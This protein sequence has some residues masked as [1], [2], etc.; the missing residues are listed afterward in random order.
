KDP[1]AR[2]IE[3]YETILS[4]DLLGN[5]GPDFKN[6][7]E[8]SYHVVRGNAID[9]TAVLDGFAITAGNADGPG[10]QG[11]GGGMFNTTSASPTVA[12]CVFVANSA[13]FGGG[14]MYNRDH[15][16]PLVTGCAFIENTTLLVG[17]AG[18]YKPSIVPRPEAVP[19]PPAV[20][21]PPAKEAVFEQK[22]A[23]ERTPPPS[24]TQAPSPGAIPQPPDPG[25]GGTQGGAPGSGGGF[26]GGQG[27]TIGSGTGQGTMDS[28][29]VRQVE[30]RVGQNWLKT[31]L[32][33]LS[34]TVHTVI[35]FEISSNGSLENIQIEQRS[36]IRS[37][38]LA[39]ER[40]V[41]ASGPLPPLPF[42]FRQRRVKFVAHFEYPPR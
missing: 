42:E 38:D 3:L 10:D 5:D 4:G 14:G 33:Q 1:D 7:E 26:G 18:M 23:P 17:G 34:R 31:S 6:N 32:G 41:R 29:Y 11:G 16:S 19:P 35:S 37:V 30:Q 8:N 39:A 22:G 12:N 21:P 9:E 20:E 36:G 40:A 15:S 28:W 25:S 24:P 13:N 2:D 27:V